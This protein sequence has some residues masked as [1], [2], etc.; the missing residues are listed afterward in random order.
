MAR[1]AAK[2]RK[3]PQPDARSAP[4]RGGRRKLNTAEEG[5]FFSRIRTHAKWAYVFLAVVFAATFAFVGV[6][7][8]NSDL[9]QLFQDI[10]RGGGGGKSISS[11]LKDTN[12]H[13]NSAQ[14]WRNL[15][16]AYRAKEG[17]VDDAIAALSTYTG[18]RPKDAA[19]LGE[20]GELQL[21]KAQNLQNVATTARINEQEA[22][23]STSFQPPTT[24]P[25]GKAF[26]QDPV[27][28]AVQSRA[29]TVSSDLTTQALTAYGQAV[30]TYKQLTKLRP[31]DS[32]AWLSL[33]QAAEQGGDTATAIAALKKVAQLEPE[34]AD[35]INARIKT[36]QGSASG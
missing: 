25:F 29:S 34:Q 22:Y 1:A 2:G 16:D 14:A 17:H 26:A 3:R 31:N 28:N 15:A 4:K 7:T 27:L 11:A 12:E 21:A 30:T 36:L 24:S 6:G 8:G 18:L 5:L 10:F 19:A 20:L 33:D 35:Q 13:P 9:T 32:A 23:A